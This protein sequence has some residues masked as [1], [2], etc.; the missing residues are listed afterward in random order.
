MKKYA[1]VE[2]SFWC[3][4]LALVTSCRSSKMSTSSG[5]E[6]LSEMKYLEEVI[7]KAPSFDTFSSKVKLNVNLNGKD[8]S[9]NGT[10]KMKK[11]DLIQLS[12]V[13]LLGIEVARLEITKDNVLIIDRMNKQ[14][15]SAPVSMLKFLANADVDFYTLQSLFFNELFLPGSKA[16]EPKD[17]K[18]F[19]VEKTDNEMFVR[20]KKSGSIG[21]CFKL[22][23]NAGQLTNT[24]IS[25]RTNYRLNWKYADFKPLASKNFPTYM[26]VSFEGAG[27]P[28]KAE[29]SFSKMETGKNAPSRTVISDK[30]KQIDTDELLKQLLNL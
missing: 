10:L 3:L 22:D 11:D 4:L 17:I 13:P 21:Y 23:A 29:F 30:Y 18:A 26:G 9:V 14:Y 25:S 8:M 28:L 19:S 27:K 20:V 7:E 2:I 6:S 16:V 12:I 1:L 15:V 24:E 5:L